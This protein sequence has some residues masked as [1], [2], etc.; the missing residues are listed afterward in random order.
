MVSDYIDE[1]AAYVRD[2]Q[3]QACL[4]MKTNQEGIYFTNDH[5]MDQFPEQLQ[6]LKM[7]VHL[8]VTVVFVFDNAPSCCKVA[9]EALNADKIKIGAGG[10]QEK[11]GILCGMERFKQW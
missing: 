2:D 7:Y 11:C 9:D 4:L 1:V 3:I 5:L 8:D 6:F 10:K